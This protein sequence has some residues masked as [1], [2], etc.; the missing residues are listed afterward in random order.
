M[1]RSFGLW[2]CEG[3]AV[4]CARSWAGAVGRKGTKLTGGG[5]LSVLKT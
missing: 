1:R 2:R 4:S 5:H 3:G